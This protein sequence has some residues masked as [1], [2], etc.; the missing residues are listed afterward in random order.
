MLENCFI[1]QPFADSTYFRYYIKQEVGILQTLNSTKS[2]ER[3]DLDDYYYDF[4]TVVVQ[5]L[6][7]VINIDLS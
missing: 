7:N 4:H 6:F 2:K 3:L 1:T 5:H